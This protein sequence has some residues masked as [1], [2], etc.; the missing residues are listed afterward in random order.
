M[1][2]PGR[3]RTLLGAGG[4]VGALLSG[5]TL[6]AAVPDFGNPHGHFYVPPAG[7]QVNTGHPD[8][9]IGNGTPASCTSAAVVREVAAGGIIT[10]SCGPKPVTILMTSTASVNK[11]RRSV[12]VD[13][14]GLITLSGG[15][16]RRI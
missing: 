10:F 5:P 3:L 6:A 8:H 2:Q 13:G 15:G 11:T 16:K 4:L 9:V 14:G 1:L 12:V 7:R